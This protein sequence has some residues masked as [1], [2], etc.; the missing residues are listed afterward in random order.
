MILRRYYRLGRMTS[1]RYHETR[2]VAPPQYH[3]TWGVIAP[4]C[5]G[6][7]TFGQLQSRSGRVDMASR[8]LSRRQ[9]YPVVGVG[10]WSDRV[11][12]GKW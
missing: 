11:L 3:G 7:I 5:H 8:G 4:R 10:S 2:G 6:D 1:P 9:S 12:C